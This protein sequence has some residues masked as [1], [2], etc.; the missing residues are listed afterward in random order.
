MD[1]NASEYG[2][3]TGRSNFRFEKGTSAI[4][5]VETTIKMT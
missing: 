2:E 4:H 1:V 5:L 3:K